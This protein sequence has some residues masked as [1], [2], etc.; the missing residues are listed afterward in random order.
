[1]LFNIQ[2]RFQNRPSPDA[3]YLDAVLS[4]LESGRL[5]EILSQRVPAV[6]SRLE[7]LVHDADRRKRSP[8]YFGLTAFGRDFRGLESFVEARLAISSDDVLKAIIFFG[9]RILLW[10][11]T[12]V[13]T[14]VR[15]VIQHPSLENG[16]PVPRFSGTGA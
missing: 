5:A 11:G 15:P 9:V 1:M 7:T 8:F 2:R 16:H 13:S 4:N 6:R 14:N 10:A 12:A 3:L